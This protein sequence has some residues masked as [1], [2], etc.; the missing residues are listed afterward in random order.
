MEGEKV[1]LVYCFVG[2]VDEVK[3]VVERCSS[4]C[5]LFYPVYDSCANIW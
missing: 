1:L 4:G 2:T 3:V 5:M